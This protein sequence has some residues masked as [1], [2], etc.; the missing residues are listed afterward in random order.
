MRVG[1]YETSALREALA[2]HGVTNVDVHPVTYDGDLVLKDQPW[3][4]VERVAAGDLDVAAV[5]GPFAGYV[6]AKKG[7]PLTIQPVNHMDDSVPLEFDLAL[8]VRRTDAVLKYQLDDALQK[9]RDEIE[10]ILTDYGV[11]LVQ[12]G[13]CIISGDIPAHGTYFTP[14]IHLVKPTDTTTGQAP[15]VADATVS[16]WLKDGLGLDAALNGAVLSGDLERIR[17][18]VD[19]G[20]NVNSRDGMGQYLL[21]TAPSNVT[22]MLLP[23]CWMTGPISRRAT[24]TGGPPLMLRCRPRQRPGHPA[25]RRTQ[26]THRCHDAGRLHGACLCAGGRKVRR[27]PGAARCRSFG[28]G[29]GRPGKIDAP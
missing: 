19:K 6:K 21:D 23:I 27:R 9:H 24:A 1:V 11:P 17:F 7:A 14:A 16:Q 20:A 15:H 22:W 3:W 4:Q 12:C 25:S 2:D 5:W 18:L 10:K 28:F 13:S 8:G 26:S 29:A